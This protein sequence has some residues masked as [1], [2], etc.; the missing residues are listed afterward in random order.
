MYV[1]VLL[2]ILFTL[3]SFLIV[4]K[5]L[6]FLAIGTEH[7]AFGGMGIAHYFGL[8][9]LSTTM[10]FCSFITV[11]AGH[12]HKKSSELGISL[13]FSA[14]MALGLILLSLSPQNTFNLQAFL[15][16]DLLAISKRELLFSSIFVA[17]ILLIILPNLNKI[18]FII[19]DRDMAFVSGIKV[20]FWNTILYVVLSVSIILGIKLVGV[21]LVASMTVLPAT[22]A[23]LWQR[24]MWQS[25]VIAFVYTVLTMIGGILLSF[26]FDT[27]PGALIVSLATGI[28]FLMKLLK[29]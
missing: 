23:L 17:V 20:D 21:L 18:L 14:S 10:I 29:R 12:T 11:F 13:L 6:S 1:A 26:Y 27:V 3:I 25:L 5:R 22:F 19:F 16:G 28:Y 4:T 15:F 2:S 9:Q 7:A 8:D 24:N